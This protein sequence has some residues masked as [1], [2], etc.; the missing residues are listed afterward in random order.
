M[1]LQSEKLQE[2]S[3]ET[4]KKF[5]LIYFYLFILKIELFSFFC[6]SLKFLQQFSLKVTELIFRSGLI[7]GLSLV[8]L[9]ALPSLNPILSCSGQVLNMKNPKYKCFKSQGALIVSA[10]VRQTRARKLTSN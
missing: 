5:F 10:S 1:R 6:E 8:I 4:E 2:G 9:R 7:D 3:L